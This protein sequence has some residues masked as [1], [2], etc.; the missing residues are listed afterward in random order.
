MKI[1][2]LINGTEEDKRPN[3]K[4]EETLD[5]ILINTAENVHISYRETDTTELSSSFIEQTVGVK[6]QENTI[7]VS[8][9]DNSEVEE[10]IQEI[11]SKHD[12][13]YHCSVCF[14]K[15]K[16]KVDA[17]RHAETHIEGLS[18]SCSDCEKTFRSRN[19]LR[20]HKSIYHKF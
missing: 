11:L 12:G 17:T 1:E 3:F 5:E 13:V 8:V 7:A 6:K 20:S 15:N 18:Y 10:K 16:R 2:G 19:S 9:K 4:S 14:Y